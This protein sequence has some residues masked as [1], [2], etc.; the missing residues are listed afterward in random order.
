MI[1]WKDEDHKSDPVVAYAMHQTD[2]V[3]HPMDDSW[4]PGV[5]IS[6]YQRLVIVWIAVAMYC[7]V[8][9]QI[10]S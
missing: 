9:R 7:G 6:C 4:N 1:G 2:N 5:G 3:A 8:L 10:T